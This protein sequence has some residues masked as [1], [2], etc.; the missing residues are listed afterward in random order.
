[1]AVNI[2][3]VSCDMLKGVPRGLKTRLDVWQ[4][5]GL[6]SYGAQNL[7][8]G[9]ATFTFIAIKYD[10]DANIDTWKASIEALQGTLVSA[11]NDHSDTFTLLLVTAVGA[12]AKKGVIYGGAARVR[13][14]IRIS[15]VQT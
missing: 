6:N 9:D 15:G 1:M 5:P 14:M 7:G 12:L 8:T 2:G 10:T 3:S 13:G 11:E 4:V